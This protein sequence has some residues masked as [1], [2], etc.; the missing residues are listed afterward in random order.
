M[1]FDRY[2]AKQHDVSDV[3]ALEE[4]TWTVSIGSNV[5]IKKYV[6]LLSLKL[7]NDSYRQKLVLKT[8][9]HSFL[10]KQRNFCLIEIV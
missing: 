1:V 3:A 10:G 4:Q 5:C 6:Q 2:V 8:N 7:T 9:K